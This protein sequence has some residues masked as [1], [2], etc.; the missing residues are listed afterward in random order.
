MTKHTKKVQALDKKTEKQ[1]LKRLDKIHKKN[2]ALFKE[3]KILLRWLKKEIDAQQR[4][5][6]AS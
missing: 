2:E 1:I 4:Q 3:D 5:R 6:K